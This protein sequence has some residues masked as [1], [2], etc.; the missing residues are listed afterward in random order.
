MSLSILEMRGAVVSLKVFDNSQ[1][2]YS[3]HVQP[4]Q[5]G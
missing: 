2:Q 1:V 5:V 3:V 4:A